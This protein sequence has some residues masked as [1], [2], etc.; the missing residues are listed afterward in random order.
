VPRQVSSFDKAIHFIIYAILAVLL[1]QRISEVTGR[2]RAAALALLLTAAFGA[3]DEWHQGFIPG[4]S[5]ELADWQAASLGAALGA[6]AVAASRR[7]NHP[8]EAAAK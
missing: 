5:T 6:L 7:R 3:A 4:R 2:W 1:A 8:P